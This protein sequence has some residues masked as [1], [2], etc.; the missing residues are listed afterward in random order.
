MFVSELD[1]FIL[2]FKQLWKAGHVAHLDV[3]ASAGKA[4]VGLRV[5]LGDPHDHQEARSKNT[6][7]RQRRRARRAAARESAVE[8]P[9]EK[10]TVEETVVNIAVVKE[11]ATTEEPSKVD[12]AVQAATPAPIAV[13]AAVQA[14]EQT[15]DR[16]VQAGPPPHQEGRSSQGVL[17]LAEQADI[18]LHH[19]LEDLLC[20]DREYLPALG[21]LADRGQYRV[22]RERER[23]EDFDNFTKMLENSFKK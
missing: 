9:S 16:A 10:A 17:G 6:P 13:D 2:K 7:S 5:Q 19:H 20:H 1:S 18:P 8:E 3:D 4:W 15:L 21:Q 14:V 23:K 12:V 22:D 11:Q